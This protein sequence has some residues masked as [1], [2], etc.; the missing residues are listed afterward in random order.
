MLHVILYAGAFIGIWTGAG[1]AIKSIQK[2]SHRLHISSF[3][4][5]FLLLGAFTSL[6]EFSVG[7]NAVIDNDPEIYV[8]NLIGATIVIFLLLIPILALLNGTMKLSKEFHGWNMITMLTAISAPVILSL[9]GFVT[10]IDGLVSI[11]LYVILLM[12]IKSRQTVLERFSQITN[13]TKVALGKEIVFM[14]FGAILIFASGHIVVEQTVYF[15]HK[16]HVSSFIMS[17]L[18]I[19]IG[20]NIPELSLMF[21]AR[22]EKGR[23][24]VLGDYIGSAAF[25]TLIFGL[26]STIRGTPV[27]LTNNYLVS[28]IVLLLGL[29][30]FYFVSRTKHEVTRKEGLMLLCLYISF[31]MLEIFTH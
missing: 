28:L 20:T 21:R 8:G 27:V 29:G 31:L 25:N 1:F 23:G 24:I 18:V 13:H 6:S 19:S 9:D 7:V 16:F 17:L 2:F 14:L 5:S 3:A 10:R 30:I 11:L 26:L 15:A 12:A 22:M 4:V